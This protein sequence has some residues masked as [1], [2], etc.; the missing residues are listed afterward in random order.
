[1][2]NWR[3][4]NALRLPLEKY[5]HAFTKILIYL[6]VMIFINFV[7]KQLFWVVCISFCLIACLLKKTQFLNRCHK[8]RWL[9][10]S[11]MLIYAFGTPGEYVTN[12]SNAF[13]PTK[14]GIVL[15][16]EQVATILMAIACLSILFYRA[17]LVQLMGG[18]HRLLMPF[19]WIGFN[20]D[21]FVIRLLLTLNYVDELT[22]SKQNTVNVFKLHELLPS[23]L[24]ATQIV[25]VEKL[26]LALLDLIAILLMFF[27]LLL[28]IFIKFFA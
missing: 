6:M 25:D 15:A 9:F 23:E 21:R 18:L 11:I 8:M 3:S 12:N 26:P 19:T 10:L 7:E 1:M 14:E 16:L 2:I 27:T 24:A 28:A 5:M 20:V 4:S 13:I 22:K 17:T